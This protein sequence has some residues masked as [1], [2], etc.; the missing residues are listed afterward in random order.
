MMTLGLLDFDRNPLS[1]Y[2]SAGGSEKPYAMQIAG[3]AEDLEALEGLVVDGVEWSF[4][5]EPG[6]AH[7]QALYVTFDDIGEK[8]ITVSTDGGSTRRG[9]G[10][11][12][13]GGFGFL[14]AGLLLIPMV[15]GTLKRT[16]K[17]RR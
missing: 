17:K 6:K 14:P 1:P 9:R 8:V 4:A 5:D 13:T 7:A 2:W 10:G 3:I 12:A 16:G 15:A 11:C